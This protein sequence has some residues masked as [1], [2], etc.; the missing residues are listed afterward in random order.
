MAGQ[1]AVE[2]LLPRKTSAP[3]SAT[4]EICSRISGKKEIS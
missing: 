3:F 1:F 2:Q 4:K